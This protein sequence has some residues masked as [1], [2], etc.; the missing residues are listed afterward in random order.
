V[1][2][3]ALVTLV[4]SA[5]LP[6]SPAAP[7]TVPLPEGM[8]PLHSWEKIAGDTVVGEPRLRVQYEF[9]VN[10]R[11]PGLYELIRYRVSRADGSA[12]A[13]HPGLEKVQWHVGANDFRRFE[14]GPAPGSSSRCRWRPMRQ[15][16]P[17]H[18][19][20]VPTILWL[21]GVH[22]SAL[23]GGPPR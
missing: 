4:L 15:G 13:A 6:V 12:T 7:F 1:R 20:E 23:A 9:Y 2:K 17:E 10:P 8:P 3:A 22:R 18:V 14:C 21:Y 11:R 5:L 16:S 19:G